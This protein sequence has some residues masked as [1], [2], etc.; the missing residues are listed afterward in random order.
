MAGE[1]HALRAALEA[2]GDPASVYEA[3]VLARQVLG[4]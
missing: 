4:L 3:R 1:R 2:L